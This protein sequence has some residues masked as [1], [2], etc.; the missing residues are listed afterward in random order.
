VIDRVW[1]AA[2]RLT[3]PGSRAIIG[4]LRQLPGRT[5]PALRERAAVRRL[6]VFLSLLARSFK[7]IDV[8]K[9]A[10]VAIVS[11]LLLS[12]CNTIHG[13]GKDIEKGGQAIEK[14]AK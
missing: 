5:R 14:A 2:A 7:E 11:A 8:N 12:A 9:F 3:A 10:F 1:P 6:S 4:R 13:V